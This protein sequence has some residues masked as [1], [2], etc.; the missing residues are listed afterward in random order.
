MIDEVCSLTKRNG[1][2]IDA[3]FDGFGFSMFA[4]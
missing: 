3:L 1:N 4:A 2:G